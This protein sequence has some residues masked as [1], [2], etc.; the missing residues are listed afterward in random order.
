MFAVSHFGTLWPTKGHSNDEFDFIRKC[1]W[2]FKSFARNIPKSWGGLQFFCESIKHRPRKI[3]FERQRVPNQLSEWLSFDEHFLGNCT[4]TRTAWFT[5]RQAELLSNL[6][7]C[8]STYC[9]HFSLH[10]LSTPSSDL[11]SNKMMSLPRWIFY[12]GHSNSVSSS[13]RL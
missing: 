11:D 9:K 13:F 8:P 4:L 2:T 3:P 5:Y 1:P 10:V 12:A 7:R 6:P